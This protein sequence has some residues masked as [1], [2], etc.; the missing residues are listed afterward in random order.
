LLV[1]W[2]VVASQ[3][4]SQEP[5]RTFKFGSCFYTNLLVML[6]TLGFSS[7]LYLDDVINEYSQWKI[8]QAERNRRKAQMFAGTRKALRR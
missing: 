4:T 6:L 5:H 1:F 3:G 2:V 8:K 7:M